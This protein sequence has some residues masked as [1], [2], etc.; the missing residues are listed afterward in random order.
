MILGDEL[1]LHDRPEDIPAIV[2]HLLTCRQIGS[3]RYSI[4]EDAMRAMVNYDWPGNVRELAN[5]LERAQILAENN[6]IT[7]DD[8]PET[9]HLPHAAMHARGPAAVSAADHLNLSE[10]ER[11]TVRMALDQEKG[12]KAQAAKR[13]G[14]SRRTLY[15]LIKKYG[16]E[17]PWPHDSPS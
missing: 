17:P 7:L 14:T 9:L 3:Y 5:V 15:R 4:D 10:L 12:N 13:L 2:A 1:P 6:T 11:R 8:L 16:L